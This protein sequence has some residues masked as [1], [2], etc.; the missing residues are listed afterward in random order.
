VIGK[1]EEE[2]VRVWGWVGEWPSSAQQCAESF[3][4]MCLLH[5]GRHIYLH[6]KNK[7]VRKERHM[8]LIFPSLL[9]S[10]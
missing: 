9:F 7:Y 3:H 10:F 2:G 5:K 4:G 1:R 8:F 6:R